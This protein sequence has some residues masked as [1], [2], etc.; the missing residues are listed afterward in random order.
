MKLLCDHMLGS[1]AKWLRIFG[2]D[3]FYPEAAM[4]DDSVLSIADHEKR[5]LIS[6][7]KELI[8]RAKKKIVP[9]LLIKTTDLSEQLHQVLKVV[10]FDEKKL[11]SRCTLC[12]TPLRP[13]EKE[14]IKDRIPEKVYKT[15]NKFWVCPSC[16]KYYWMGTHY[17]NMKEKINALVQKQSS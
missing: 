9:V 5:L 13:V 12:N 6:R 8:V 17:E 11:L 4:D 3:T 1:L 16:S 14:T 15:R 2:Y 7:D 10:P